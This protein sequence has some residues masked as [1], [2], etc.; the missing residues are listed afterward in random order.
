MA[1]LLRRDSVRGPFPGPARSTT[2][3]WYRARRRALLT[4]DPANPAD[5]PWR[6]L[7]VESWSSDRGL[8][9]GA[10]NVAGHLAAGARKV[11]LAVSA[12]GRVEATI[13]IGVNDEALRPEHVVVSSASG[14]DELPGPPGRRP[15]QDFGLENGLDDGDRAPTPATRAWSMRRTPICGAAARPALNIVPT[16]TEPRAPWARCCRT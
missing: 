12:A 16:T 15:G 5:L 14:T 4:A 11:V 7:G 10:R 13:V 6:R 2:A 8:P 3:L 1:Y 9:H